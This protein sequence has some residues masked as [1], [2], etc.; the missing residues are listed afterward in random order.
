VQKERDKMKEQE[1]KA[2]VVVRHPD[3]GGLT[4]EVN[5]HIDM[6]YAPLGG[7]SSFKGDLY[8]IHA[9]AMLLSL[10]ADPVFWDDV[11]NEA[12]GVS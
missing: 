3:I 4:E 12:L 8:V 9:Q 5:R 7:L 10:W 6:G 1:K 11:P 2:Y